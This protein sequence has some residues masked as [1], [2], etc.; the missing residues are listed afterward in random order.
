[1][2]YQKPIHNDRTCFRTIGVNNLTCKECKDDMESMIC[3]TEKHHGRIK[4]QVCANESIKRY[5]MNKK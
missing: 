1:M 5:C 2:Q 4:G 3:L